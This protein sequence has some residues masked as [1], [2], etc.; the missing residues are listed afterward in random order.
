M[1]REEK[2]QEILTNIRFD[3]PE[4]KKAIFEGIDLFEEDNEEH[5]F[6]EKENWNEEYIAK[7]IVWLRKNFSKKR[8]QHLLEVR[9]YVRGEIKEP[10]EE[11]PKEIKRTHKISSNEKNKSM[12]EKAKENGKKIINS[13]KIL[14]KYIFDSPKK[15]SKINKEK[16]KY[17]KNF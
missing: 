2:I 17:D 5:P 3:L 7:N 11:Y 8:L 16:E 15:K 13:G 10:K 9:D 14:Y 4:S 6:E 12:V 1:T